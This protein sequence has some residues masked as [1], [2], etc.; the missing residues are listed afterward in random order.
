TIGLFGVRQRQARDFF[1]FRIVVD[2]NVFA[3]QDLPLKIFVLDLVLAEGHGLRSGRAGGGCQ[4]P[5]T[6]REVE[7][8]TADAA[9]KAHDISIQR[10]ISIRSIGSS[11]VMANTASMLPASLPKT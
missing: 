2:V 10:T 6:K 1:F 9:I 8:K 7:C 5:G 11:C 4:Q 3:R